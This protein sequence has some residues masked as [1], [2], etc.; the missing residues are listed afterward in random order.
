MK[1]LFLTL[2]SSADK[3]LKYIYGKLPVDSY[4]VSSYSGRKEFSDIDIVVTSFPHE[5]IEMGII[6]GLSVPS[7]FVVE[8]LNNYK[9]HAGDYVSKIAV[10]SHNMREDFM[11][12]G[13]NTN[14]LV[15]TGC[16]RFETHRRRVLVALSA[17]S[18][19]ELD[20]PEFIEKVKAGA[21]E[22]HVNSEFIFR[23]HPGVSGDKT[24]IIDWLKNC[25]VVVTSSSTILLHALMMSKRVILVDSKANLFL[26]KIH[27]RR[28]MI[29]KPKICYTPEEV[30][31]QLKHERI[32]TDYLHESFSAARNVIKLMEDMVNE[33]DTR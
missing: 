25:D 14:K 27:W 4:Y 10:W 33:H 24:E 32:V 13:W 16:P 21:E 2:N 11:E 31:Q 22:W 20:I 15:V 28:F 8:G 18:K 5:E 1:S 9:Y 30:V 7:L 19:E 29:C 23:E 26:R 3:L 6:K 12:C 17:F